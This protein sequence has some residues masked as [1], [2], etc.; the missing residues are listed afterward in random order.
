M[1]VADC[2]LEVEVEAEGAGVEF[3]GEQGVKAGEVDDDA[4]ARGW[5]AVPFGHFL[6]PGVDSKFCELAIGEDGFWCFV[7]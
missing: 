4:V 1:A 3:G 6:N 7:F 5:V 2:F